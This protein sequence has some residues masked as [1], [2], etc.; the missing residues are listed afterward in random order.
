MER[1]GIENQI[2]YDAWMIIKG[3]NKMKRLKWILRAFGGLIVLGLIGCSSEDSPSAKKNNEDFNRKYIFAKALD[4]TAYK[5]FGGIF[6]K[7]EI[8]A[9]ER[10]EVTLDMRDRSA[11]ALAKQL[12]PKMREAG[13]AVLRIK[14]KNSDR[15]EDITL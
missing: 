8:G 1:V 13:F 3:G 4:E 9:T 5:D 2:G 12:G 10:I 6:H 11:Y 15:Y 14:D 7:V